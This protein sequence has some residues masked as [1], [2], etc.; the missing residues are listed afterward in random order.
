M[1]TPKANKLTKG[2]LEALAI[3]PNGARKRLGLSVKDIAS[4][5]QAFT[6]PMAISRDRADVSVSC[7]CCTPCCCAAAMPRGTSVR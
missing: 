7:C 2:D 3:D 5:K 1:L 6:T 4:I